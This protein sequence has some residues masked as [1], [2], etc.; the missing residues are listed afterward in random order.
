MIQR[1]KNSLAFRSGKVFQKMAHMLPDPVYRSAPPASFRLITLTGKG[2]LDMLNECLMSI[3]LFW[4][5]HPKLILGSDGSCDAEYIRKYISW[6]KGPVEIISWEDSRDWAQA[7]G[8]DNL[9]RFS[10][11][12]AMGKK[13]CFTMHLA[14]SGEGT[15]WCDSDFL[16][17]DDF[18][19]PESEHPVHMMATEDYQP[20]YD[21]SLFPVYPE[22][23]DKLPWINAG[24]LWWKGDYLNDPLTQ[25]LITKI[26][27][28]GNHFTEQTWM[29][30]RMHMGNYPIFPPE[31]ITCRAEDQKTW[32]ISFKNKKWLARHYTGVIRHLFWRDAL[33]LRMGIRPDGK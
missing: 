21:P 1:I 26:P 11:N 31:R 4:T 18:T 16:W 10:E 29:A 5:K 3:N 28:T 2:Y 7:Q 22:L 20:S 9:A 6:W 19:A 24:I 25:F 14:A 33:A 12:A 27:P 8:L 13:L 23:P 30:I 17:Y 32:H 15:L